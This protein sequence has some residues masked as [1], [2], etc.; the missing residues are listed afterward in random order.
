MRRLRARFG[1]PPVRRTPS[2]TE[3]LAFEIETVTTNMRKDQDL[4]VLYW[5]MYRNRDMVTQAIANSWSRLTA[6]D[7]LTLPERALEPVSAF[8]D[9][10]DDFGLW[11]AHTEVM[12]ATLEA[13]I[14]RA[15]ERLEL[16]SVPALA[17]LAQPL[18]D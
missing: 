13:R 2:V 6:G 18:L 4:M 17:A 16:L 1:L 15:T 14:E 8:F 7:L 3:R 11:V 12:P 10:L 9:A 5:N